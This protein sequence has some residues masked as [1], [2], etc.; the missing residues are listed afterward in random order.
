[1]KSFKEKI[2]L[3]HPFGSKSFER[4]GGMKN[5]CVDIAMEL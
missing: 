3:F 4:S 2:N 1:M 5:R